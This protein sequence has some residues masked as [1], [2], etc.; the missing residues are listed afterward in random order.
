MSKLFETSEI[1]GMQLSN[2]FVRSATM[3]G[4]AADGGES[5]PK[6]SNLMGRLAQGR[7]SLI[8]TG[9]AC[10]SPDGKAARRQLGISE[11]SCI[12]G[13]REMTRAVHAHDGKIM[14]QLSHAG[15]FSYAKLTGKTPMAPSQV[16]GFA[17]TPRKEMSLE[18]INEVTGAFAQAARRALEAEFDGIQVHGAHGYLFNQFLSPA[19]NKRSDAYG[20]SVENRSRFLADTIR[21]IRSVI[22]EQFPIVVKL[23]AQDFIKGGMTLND[24][25][26]I[27]FILQEAGVDALEI[28][29]GTPISGKFGASRTKIDAEEKEAYFRKEARAFKEK[30]DIPII[31]VGGIRSFHLAEQLVH[32]GAADYISMCRPLIREPDLVARWESGDFRKSSC[33]SDNG[34]FK[35]AMKET[36]IYCVVE[37]EEKKNR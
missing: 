16:E 8:I 1:N 3:E 2:R 29:G 34:C 14:A 25:V 22:G 11:D 10:V 27:G 15:F 5:T 33:I 23:N 18:E 6:L 36:G 28:S 21:S 17:K 32:E 26:Q 12:D 30:L 35:A 37:E 7:V 24:S 20:G 31:A 13:L 19:F 4:L 9:H